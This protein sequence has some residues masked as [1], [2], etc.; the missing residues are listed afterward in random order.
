MKVYKFIVFFVL[1]LTVSMSAYAAGDIVADATVTPISTQEPS[2][3]V[4]DVKLIYD[5]NY[6]ENVLLPGKTLE[7]EVN[8]L[9]STNA[10]KQM[11]SHIVQYDTSGKFSNISSA[12]TIDIAAQQSASINVS[13]P[14]AEN[15]NGTAS[16]IAIEKSES[17]ILYSYRV[18]T[19]WKDTFGD[20]FDEAYESD[21]DHGIMGK[22]NSDADVDVIKFTATCQSV[23]SIN[24]QTESNV[25]YNIYDSSQQMING[26]NTTY[27]FINGETYYIIITGENN[28]EYVVSLDASDYDFIITKNIG[29][30]AQITPEHTSNTFMFIPE[31]NGKTIT[32]YRVTS[33]GDSYLK[34]N[35][36]DSSGIKIAESVWDGGYAYFI[37]TADL[38][39]NEAY[40]IEVLPENENT[41]ATYSYTLFVEEYLF[42]IINIRTGSF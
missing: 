28:S 4:A 11:V 27:Q 3:E 18:S 34:A 20:N 10:S 17:N 31:D 25:S 37:L 23:C 1:S 33:V 29:V 9:N 39:P 5:G 35:L 26:N 22:I 19:A 6:S 30:L 12:D 40:F 24:L 13:Q 2:V 41:S 36:Y 42:D 16:I 15:Y 38:K 32:T 8:I 7:A 14:F 21:L